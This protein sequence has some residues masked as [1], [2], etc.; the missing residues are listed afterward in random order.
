MKKP[1]IVYLVSSGEYSDYSI[2]GAFSSREK[3]Q[4]FIEHEQ[5]R[6]ASAR[7]RD[8]YDIEE[9]V[10]DAYLDQ[11][12]RGLAC[13]YVSFPDIMSGNARVSPTSPT[14]DDDEGDASQP[15]RDKPESFWVDVWAKDKQGAL[16]IANERRAKF[17]AQREGIGA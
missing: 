4:A 13:Y 15:Y 8:S 7:Y 3:A 11:L 1:K 14:D 12:E 5:K 17:L 9:Y 10:L 16:K 2:N 6:Q